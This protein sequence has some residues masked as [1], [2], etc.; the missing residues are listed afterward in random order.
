MHKVLVTGGAGY[1]GS[2]TVVALI[3]QGFTPVIYDNLSNSNVEVLNRIERIS[4]VRPEF[5]KGDLLDK[6]KLNVLFSE[7]DFDSVIHFAGLKAVGESVAQPL[8]YYQNNVS[9]TLVL[10]EVMQAYKVLSLVFSSSATVY[11]EPNEMPITED[12]P[13][14]TTNPYG[15]T[16]IVIENILR[17]LS[18][19]SP[20]WQVSLLR[21][22]NPVSAHESGLIGEDPDGI[23]NNLM[24]YIAQVGVG[25]LEQLSVFGDD[26]PTP[27]GTGVRDYIHVVDLARAHIKALEVLSKP[28][29]GSDVKG[30]AKKYA[31]GCQ[32]YNIGTG[33]GYSVLQMV[34]AFERASGQTIKYQIKPR[35]AGDI[36]T[37]YADTS[38]SAKQLGWRSEFDL[39]RMMKD[40]WRWQSNNPNGYE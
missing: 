5:L 2:H 27:D 3:E 32:A 11:G 12:F 24:P 15:Q 33:V 30:S 21:Y 31:H 34:Q 16:K 6:A 36:A 19:A 29:G 38:K 1:I 18:V 14:S 37:C 13:M 22:F 4:G 7:H 23:P 10:L 28:V 35:R 20:E 9:G 39:D 40:G 25:K 26:Y 17:D 8:R